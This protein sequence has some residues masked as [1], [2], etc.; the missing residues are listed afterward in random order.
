MRQQQQRTKSEAAELRARLAAEEQRMHELQ[1]VSKG[2]SL[3]PK[4]KQPWPPLPPTPSALSLSPK[5]Y[6]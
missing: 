4:P 1:E 5:P 2:L 3:S 6:A